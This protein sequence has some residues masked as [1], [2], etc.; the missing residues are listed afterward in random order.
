MLIVSAVN[1]EFE[2]E[3]SEN[4]PVPQTILLAQ[5]LRI[6]QLIIVVNKMDLTHP[7]YSE[8]CYNKLKGKLKTYLMKSNFDLRTIPFIPISGLIGDNLVVRSPKLKWYKGW[9][10]SFAQQKKKFGIS[11]NQ[12]SVFFSVC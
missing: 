6:K 7:P 1:E 5:A 2:A 12:F 3:I 8:S 4:S 9:E 10:I 11:L